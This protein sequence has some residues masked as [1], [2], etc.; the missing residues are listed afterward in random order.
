MGI[1]SLLPFVD[2]VAVPAHLSDFN[3]RTAAIDGYAWL[4]RGS[5]TCAVEMARGTYTTK[6]VEYCI[7]QVRLLRS[8]GV[9]PYVVLDGAPLPAKALTEEDRRR[10][11]QAARAAANE[12]LRS[13]TR[14]RAH[15]AY[16]AAVNITPEHAYQL[17]LALRR[18]GV[19][20]V[21]AP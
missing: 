2:A 21:V 4:H 18:R 6:F 12:L 7:K 10:K 5:K 14:E 19:K 8:N 13:G 16:N 3:G 15:A 17:I 20:Y 1:Q 9:E 11:R